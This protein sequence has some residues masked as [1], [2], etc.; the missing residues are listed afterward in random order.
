MTGGQMMEPESGYGNYVIKRRN[1][2]EFGLVWLVLL[3][4]IVIDDELLT[5]MKL[6]DGQGNSEIKRSKNK[7]LDV[8]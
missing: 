2:I 6:E 1:F 5:M 8:S 7:S 3:R 4:T